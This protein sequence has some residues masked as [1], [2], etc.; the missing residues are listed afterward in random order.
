MSVPSSSDAPPAPPQG[1]SRRPRFQFSLLGLMVLM[2]AMSM[3][4]TPVYYF[5]RGNIEGRSDMKLIGMIAILAGPLLLTIL[6]SLLVMV[7]LW[8][9]RK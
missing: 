2:L 1:V 9:A 5:M 8:L 6:V 7:A 4:G 3:I